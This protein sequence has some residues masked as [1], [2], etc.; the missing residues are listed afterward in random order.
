MGKDG[1]VRMARYTIVELA[2]NPSRKSL[3]QAQPD[4]PPHHHR[5]DQHE[6]HGVEVELRCPPSRRTLLR[7]GDRWNGRARDGD[8]EVGD[9]IISG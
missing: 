5:D 8:G 4:R 6:D 7:K 2:S 1:V 9:P 3:T